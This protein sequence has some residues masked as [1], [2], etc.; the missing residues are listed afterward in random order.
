[1]CALQAVPQITFGVLAAVATI[2]LAPLSEVEA[3]LG[4][5]GAESVLAPLL[6]RLSER[7]LL[8]AVSLHGR[9]AVVFLVFHTEIPLQKLQGLL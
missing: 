4:G 7:E 9:D 6:R 2:S 3:T 5:R 8:G 1:M